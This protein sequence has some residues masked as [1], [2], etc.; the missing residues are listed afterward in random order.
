MDDSEVSLVTKVGAVV[1][2]ADGDAPRVLL[3]Q[4]KPK[5]ATPEDLPPMGLPRGTRMYALADG[6]YVD[7]NHDGNTPPPAG[8]TLE[9]VA[10]TFA[11][12]VEEE[13]GVNAAMLAR[14]SVTEM[15]V[16][17][18]AS[19][20]K[21]PYP[22]HWFVVLLHPADAEAVATAPLKDSLHVQWV[23]LAELRALVESGKASAG[24]VAVAEEGMR[25]ALQTRP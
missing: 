19:R 22:I 20:S 18:F 17:L 5:P 11:R 15:G 14:A 3:V 24:Y 8:A 25:Y 21:P 16:R 13:A 6:N 7:A 4:P 10:A 2:R 12:E 9:A 23:M 1:L